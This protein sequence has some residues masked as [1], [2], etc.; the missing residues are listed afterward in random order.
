MLRKGSKETHLYQFDNLFA[1]PTS[2]RKVAFFT[3][4]KRA[5]MAAI[6]K[7]KTKK[8][9]PLKHDKIPQASFH[10]QSQVLSQSSNA[11]YS[12]SK[13]QWKR[14]IKGNAGLD[15][16]VYPDRSPNRKHHRTKKR[17]KSVCSMKPEIERGCW[18]PISVSRIRRKMIRS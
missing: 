14:G 18:R 10:D 11:G 16:S 13:S 5:N 12:D 3:Q 15:A 17:K 7:Q 1:L 8:N 9:K 2:L 4:F 6:E